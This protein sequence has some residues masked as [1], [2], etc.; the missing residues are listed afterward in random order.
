MKLCVFP[1]DPISASYRK[2]EIKERY[3][4]PC[5]FFDEIHIISFVD[6]DIEE[7]KVQ[8]IA[9]NAKFEIHS[10]GKI[11]Y[12]NKGKKSNQVLDLIKHLSP[13]VIRSYNTLLEG[14]VAAKC[15]KQLNIPFFVSIHVQYDG[16][17]KLVQKNN[18][19]K[20]LALKY[21]RKKIEPF[22]ISQANK[23]TVVYKIIEPYVTEIS[24]KKPEILYNRI[25]LQRFGNG[26]KILDYD[27][28]LILSVGRLSPQKN[29]ECIIKA[30]KDLDVYLMIIGDGELSHQIE[31]LISKLSLNE[32][33]ILKK[34]V[35]NNEIQDY[36]ASADLFALAYDPNIEGVPIPVF[37]AMASGTPVLIS[38]PI[39]SF[40][41]GLDNAVEFSDINPE[42][43]HNKIKKI[44]NDD[45]FSK[46]L[47]LKGKEKSLE[48]DGNITEKREAEIYKELI[49]PK[50]FS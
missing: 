8:T 25:D 30:I 32:K 48:F 7:S 5:N 1:N 45:S 34:S 36:Y 43:F 35:P 41:D 12:F 17:R 26:K 4:N 11:N 50:K 10:V 3:Y 22:T 16:L 13:D 42:S 21:S 49:S 14:W 15:S 18:Y 9:G 38:K 19:K 29:H 47:S 27:K 20:F 6:K 40:S 28:P 23:I 39:P 2:G 37:E 33:V 44:L 31:N 24:N 46:S